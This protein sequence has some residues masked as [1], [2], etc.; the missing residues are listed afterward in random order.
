MSEKNLTVKIS[1][2]Q[3]EIL[4]LAERKH[5]MTGFKLYPTYAIFDA[6]VSEANKVKFIAAVKDAAAQ[7]EE[8]IKGDFIPVNSRNGFGKSANQLVEKLKKFVSTEIDIHFGK[9]KTRNRFK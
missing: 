8:R 3:W 5:K 9:V 6:P 4:E 2:K 1:Q 7:T